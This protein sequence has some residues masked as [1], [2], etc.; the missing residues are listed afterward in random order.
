M[1]RW[2]GIAAPEE[3]AAA[4]S[5]WGRIWHTLT[6]G[7]WVPSSLPEQLGAGT[8]TLGLMG[9]A[10]CVG[11]KYAR[12]HGICVRTA[13]HD[14]EN[15]RVRNRSSKIKKRKKKPKSKWMLWTVLT[16]IAVVSVGV[17]VWYFFYSGNKDPSPEEDFEP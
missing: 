1:G 9:G 16:A 4:N 15:P 10:A 2:F 14:V 17:A 5:I 13:E 3:A 7:Y 8:G 6:F 11:A 12:R